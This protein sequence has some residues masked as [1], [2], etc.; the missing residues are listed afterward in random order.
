MVEWSCEI[1]YIRTRPLAE[2]P[3]ADPARQVAF[4]LE[5]FLKTVADAPLEPDFHRL[6][7]RVV[8]ALVMLRRKDGSF[9]FYKGVNTEVAIQTGSLCAER[10][11]IAA[12]R[13]DFPDLARF[14]ICAIGT[15]YAPLTRAEPEPAKNPSWPCGVCMEWIKKACGKSELMR[16][17]GFPNTKF[18]TVIEKF[19]VLNRKQPVDFSQVRLTRQASSLPRTEQN[20]N[21]TLLDH[22][23]VCDSCCSVF[24]EIET[25]LF[26]SP[27]SPHLSN[28]P[29]LRTKR[30]ADQRHATLSQLPSDG[31]DGEFKL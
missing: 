21:N 29:P 20:P 22:L 8:L 15:I 2:L 28:V 23:R 30:I 19:L 14:E 5:N 4:H 31:A 25:C 9:A 12:A 13:A 10:A 18:D 1:E 16:I 7:G 11:A 27:G 3:P 26:C 24:P 6:S 17:I